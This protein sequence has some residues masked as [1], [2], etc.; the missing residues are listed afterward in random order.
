MYVG[1]AVSVKW[2]SLGK[3]ETVLANI[4]LSSEGGLFKGLGDMVD[5]EE[6]SSKIEKQIHFMR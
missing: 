6:R 1:V 3:V 2:A 5:E 4:L